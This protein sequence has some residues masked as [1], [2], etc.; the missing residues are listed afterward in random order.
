M[1][2]QVINYAVIKKAGLVDGGGVDEA[3]GGPIAVG[4]P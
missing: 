4:A 1:L 3:R 2:H